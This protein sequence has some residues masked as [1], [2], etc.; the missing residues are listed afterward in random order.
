MSAQRAFLIAFLGVAISSPLSLAAEPELKLGQIRDGSLS[1]GQAQSFM[2][3]LADGDFA[4]I[5]VNP[6]GLTLVVKTYDPSG[7][8]F[9]G[10]E[11]GP[12][13]DK[14]ALVAEA[15]GVYRI[16]VAAVDSHA[17]GSY[18]IA[19]EKVVTLAAR[20]EPP[21]PVA[22]SQRMRA[23]Q[24]SLQSGDH[25]SIN[26]FWQEVTKTGAPLIEPIAGDRNNMAVTF[27]WRG[28]P[29]ICNVLV[30]WLPY[31]GVAPDEYMMDRL[32]NTD[33]W[34]KTIKVDRRMRL[35]YT[36]APN[37]ARL[38]PLSL[39]IDGDAITMTA[40][41]ARPDPLNPKRYRV[42]PES[43]DA[44]EFRGQSIL[45]MPDALPQPWVVRRPGVPAGRVEKL[46]YKSA[47]LDNEREVAVY[48]PPQ[49]SPQAKPYPLLVLFD[50]DAYLTLVPTPTILDNLIAEGRI[51]PMVA[52]LIG[53]AA[54]D[55]RD[56]E[57]LCNPV[58]TG[59]L[60]TELLPW[61]HG[62]YNFTSD[63][64][65]TVVAGSSLGGIGA[66]CAGL[67]HSEI[68]G[69]VLAQSGAFHRAPPS[70]SQAGQSG[71][72]PNWLLRQFI[73]SPVKP[74]RFYLDAGSAEFNATGGSDSILFCTRTLRDVLLAK[75]YQVYFQEFVG[76]HDYLSW[77]GTLADG[78][79]VL[80]GNAAHKAQPQHQPAQ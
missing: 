64:R 33:V 3:S 29:D 44:P 68:F 24:A 48:L 41:A 32:G 22:E 5:A 21:K 18:T 80:L 17:S 79:I 75:G 19:L 66:A 25:Q 23:L 8:L 20:L 77:R 11:S 67:W 51:P 62:R 46:P 37:A 72:E 14:L 39:G 60:A 45:E 40:A 38:H 16:E 12:Q 9:R 31:A 53:N 69:N 54:G 42:D 52:L 73:A 76:G 49:Y 4:Q 74:L 28:R 70:A 34:Y 15:S 63:P 50:E 10:G 2:V 65:L 26:A 36:L 7:H 57:L 43:V 61:A 35:A 59:A 58:F 13:E 71:T 56:H 78:L 55:A 6:R 1:P 30:L 27:L 47:A